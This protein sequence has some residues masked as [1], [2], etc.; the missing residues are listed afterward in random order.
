MTNARRTA[1]A[2]RASHTFAC[3]RRRPCGF[4]VMISN[5]SA[6]DGKKLFTVLFQ[7]FAARTGSARE[8]QLL[9]ASPLECAVPA[10]LAEEMHHHMAKPRDLVGDRGFLILVFGSLERPV[11]E[12]RPAYDVLARHKSPVA[13]IEA[14]V[15]VV[16]HHEKPA[17]RHHEIAVRN[18]IGKV[19]RPGFG[20][21][22]LRC[23]RDS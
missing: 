16:A 23:R 13:G 21:A 15:P 10:G 4:S 17:R 18:V 12:Q 11:V 22:G 7:L 6:W 19:D 20:G 3:E 9:L 14:V 2:D 5:G 8:L 1:I